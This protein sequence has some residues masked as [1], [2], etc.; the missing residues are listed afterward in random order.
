MSY[1][2]ELRVRAKTSRAAAVR[3]GGHMAS[4]EQISLREHVALLARHGRWV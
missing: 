2:D 1:R 4:E 3:L